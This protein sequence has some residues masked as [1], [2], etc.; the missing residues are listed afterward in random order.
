MIVTFLGGCLK[1][2]YSGR[3]AS[4]P[5]S[6]LEVSTNQRFWQPPWEHQKQ[7]EKPEVEWHDSMMYIKSCLIYLLWTV[8]FFNVNVNLFHIM[9][10]LSGRLTCMNQRYQKVLTDMWSKPSDE[11]KDI[12]IISGC[13]YIFVCSDKSDFFFFTKFL[14]V[15]CHAKSG[16]L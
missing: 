6:G 5:F 2:I 7:L 16:N 1:K 4:V 10:V 12:L 8:F 11:L 15:V 9:S 14:K 3:S 13:K